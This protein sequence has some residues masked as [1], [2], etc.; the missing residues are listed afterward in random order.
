MIPAA[1][2][3]TPGKRRWMPMA[4]PMNSARSVAIAMTSAWIHSPTTAG[5]GNFNRQ[6]SARLSPVAMPSFALMDWTSIAMRL[7]A[8]TTHSSMYPYFAPPATLV[9][10]FPG[11]TYATAATNA[12]PR[13]GRSARRPRVWPLRAFSAARSTR[14]SPGS[15]TATGSGVDLGGWVG[16]L[17]GAGG[18]FGASTAT[19]TGS[20]H[21]HAARQP[22]RDA[23]PPALDPDLDGTLVLALLHDFDASA[24]HQAAPVQLTEPA[25]VV[26]RDALHDHLLPRAAFAERALAQRAHLAPERWDGQTVGIELR[27]AEQLEDPL[28][29]GFHVH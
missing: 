12:G 9:A 21:E 13:K 19:W 6:T 27:S 7:A 4:A 8:R 10:K 5:N 24:R 16:V 17:E 15:A 18:G 2:S 26:V 28:L 23:D 1:K 3:G 20:F 22:E 29:P 25:G 14:S 11:S